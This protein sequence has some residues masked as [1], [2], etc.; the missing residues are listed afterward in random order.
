MSAATTSS[1]REAATLRAPV[2]QRRS[3]ATLDGILTATGELF[4][5][6]GPDATT[7]EA[8]AQR[9]NVSIGSVYRFFENRTAVEA[10]LRQRVRE[11]FA[12]SMLAIFEES[13]LRR[14]PEAVVADFIARFCQVLDDVPGTRGLLAGAIARR[15]DQTIAT[16]ASHIERLVEINA[17]GIGPARRK[18]AARTYFATSA[19]LLINASRAGS[20]LRGELLE[21]RA[22]LVG[23]LREL[24]REAR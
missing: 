24:A 20:Q 11:R 4:D 13:S 23:Y 6:L 12:E 14:R 2:R 22:V 8:I 21:V 15:S 17:P 1:S 10:V 16:Y 5:E 18:R 9:A 7:M 3:R 19:S